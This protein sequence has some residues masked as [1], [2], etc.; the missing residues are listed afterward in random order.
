MV[1]TKSSSDTALPILKWVGGKRSLLKEIDLILPSPKEVGTYFE[2]F[3]GAGAVLFSR[4]GNF[5]LV[6]SD[7]NSDLINLYK[8]IKKFPNELIQELEMYPNDKDFF[9]QLRKMDRTEG[10]KSASDL[11]K[12][13]RM[14]YLN[15][16]CFNGLYRVNSRGEFNV[17]FGNYSRPNIVEAERIQG[18]S[19][20]LNKKLPNRQNRVSIIEADFSSVAANA[21]KGDVVYFDPPYDPISQTASFTSYSSSGFG[22][23]D[24]ENLRDLCIELI[25]VNKAKVVVSNSAT[26]NIYDLYNESGLFTFKKVSVAR[27]VAAK[28]SSRSPAQEFLITSK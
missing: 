27:S 19:A 21:V 9:Y 15:K 11:T 5:K 17:P 2:P 16:T 3:L 10:W 6:G 7:T 12:A 18:L 4:V 14:L 26:Q 25:Q 24:Q 22:N 1:S 8:V 13:A 28:G 20:L 23:F